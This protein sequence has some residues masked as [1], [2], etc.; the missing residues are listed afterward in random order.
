RLDQMDR[1]FMLHIKQ[2]GFSDVQ[3]AYLS[4][5]EASEDDVRQHRLSLGLSPSFLLVDTCAGEFPAQTPYYYSTYEGENES[6]ASDRRKVI[7][8]GGEPNRIEQGI[9]FDYSCVH[10]V[11]A[12][13]AMGY[14]TLMINCNPETVSTDFDVADKLYFE[15]VYWE[16]VLDIIEMEGR[17]TIEG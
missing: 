8:L 9:E 14:E 13:K 11:L 10:G 7:I 17:D 4:R 15:P 5:D 6:E 12:A 2:Y 1:D 3:I 16:R